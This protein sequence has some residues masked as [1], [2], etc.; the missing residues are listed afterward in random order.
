MHLGNWYRDSNVKKICR[1]FE[2]VRNSSV[3]KVRVPKIS[4]WVNF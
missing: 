4:N 1:P 3:T 2:N